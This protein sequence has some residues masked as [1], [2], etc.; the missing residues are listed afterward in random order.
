MDLGRGGD[1]AGHGAAAPTQGG[2]QKTAP[3]RPTPATYDRERDLPRLTSVW[4]AELA[5]RSHQGRARL[6]GRLR[7]ALREERQRGLA[8]HW[9]Y[10]L[11]R[12]AQLL[13]AY[14]VEIAELARIVAECS[15]LGRLET[16]RAA[17][18]RHAALDN[19]AEA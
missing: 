13:A 17:G 7:R 8:G 18:L 15:V 10:D 1:T 14:R 19:D 6:V 5:D 16:K 3:Y 11:A 4:P 12:H 9:T 2:R